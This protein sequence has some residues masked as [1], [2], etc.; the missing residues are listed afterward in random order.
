MMTGCPSPVVSA[1]Q[2]SIK[3]QVQTET[4]STQIDHAIT[5]GFQATEDLVLRASHRGQVWTGRVQAV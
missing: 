5:C 4:I 1:G 2:R 3:Q